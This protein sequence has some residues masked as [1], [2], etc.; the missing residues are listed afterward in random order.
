MSGL[1]SNTISAG[2]FTNYEDKLV[3][4]FKQDLP[5]K[6]RLLSFA[7]NNGDFT[8]VGFIAHHIHHTFGL[9]GASKEEAMA[10][11]LSKIYLEDEDKAKQFVKSFTAH[12]LNVFKP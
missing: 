10:L 12:V 2:D 5:E 11:Q 1:D 7:A 9:L 6:L 3:F 8:E 4:S